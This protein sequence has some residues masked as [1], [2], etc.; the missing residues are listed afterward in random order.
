M[1]R[2]K[3]GLRGAA[4]GLALLAAGAASAQAQAAGVERDYDLSGFDRISV[5]GAFEIDVT[6][7]GD[8]A[9]T[10]EGREIDLDRAVVEVTGGTLVLGLEKGR[11]DSFKGL[12]ALVALPAL[13]GIEVRG[14]ADLDAEGITADDFAVSIEGVAGMDLAGTCGSLALSMAGAANVDAEELVCAEAVV[15][16][17]GAGKA[18]IHATERATANID[19]VGAIA[20]HGDPAEVTKSPGLLGSVTLE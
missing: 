17:E 1:S 7:G 2:I 5:E 6:V 16:I 9:V 20:I 11:Y 13:S 15:S 18:E 3:T 14:A 8:F 4:A 12:T 19:G 10:V